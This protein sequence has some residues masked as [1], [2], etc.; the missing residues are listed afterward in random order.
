[1]A[2]EKSY[3]CGKDKLGG[4]RPMMKDRNLKNFTGAERC[5]RV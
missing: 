4:K 3:W 5:R 2:G 1:V